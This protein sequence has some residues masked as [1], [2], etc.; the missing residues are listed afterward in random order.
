[1]TW[2]MF[3]SGCQG[4]PLFF[5]HPPNEHRLLLNVSLHSQEMPFNF[6]CLQTKLSRSCSVSQEYWTKL[7]VVPQA[8]FGVTFLQVT[9]PVPHYI[10]LCSLFSLGQESWNRDFFSLTRPAWKTPGSYARLSV[11]CPSSQTAEA[12]SH[13]GRE[14]VST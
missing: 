1:M 5:T 12:V 7:T 4:P 14:E 8:M 9:K 11:L 13:R 3:F 10:S 2:I 6:Y